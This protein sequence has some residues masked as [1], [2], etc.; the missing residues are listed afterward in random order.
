MSVQLTGLNKYCNPNLRGLYSIQYKPVHEITA[1][2][3]AIQSDGTIEGDFTFS[4]GT[5]LTASIIPSINKPIFEIGT[6]DSNPG[7]IKEVLL[8]ALILSD[9]EDI[10]DELNKMERMQFVL[11][12]TDKNQRTRILGSKETPLSFTFSQTINNSSNAY[13]V[14]FKGIMTHTPYIY[15]S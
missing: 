7:N 12:V 14:Q 13:T 8:R 5:W 3:E 15:T 11:K 10:L 9:N 2:P 1:E 6:N 4:S